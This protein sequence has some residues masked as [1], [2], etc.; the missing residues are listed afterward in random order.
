[1][2]GSKNESNGPS[3]RLTHEGRLKG[4]STNAAESE[5]I[6][7]TLTWDGDLPDDPSALFFLRVLVA[8]W[9]D[10]KR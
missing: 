4:E 5:V 10:A 3:P 1:M 2:K 7:A 6:H 9:P 8:R